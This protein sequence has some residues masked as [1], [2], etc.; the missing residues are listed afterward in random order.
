MD[1]FLQNLINGIALGSIYALIA[2]GYTMVYGVLRLINFAHGDVFMVGAF[3]GYYAA[4]T[5][6]SSARQPT[7]SRRARSCSCCCVRCVV[8]GALGPD[9]AARLPAAAHAPRLTS[10][11]TAIGV[12]LLLENGG[13]LRVR[14]R[15]EV[16]PAA[17]RKHQIALLGGDDHVDTS[18]IVLVV[19]L[20]L[21]AGLQY[22]VYRTQVRPRD[23]RGVVQ[24]DGRGADGDPDR[25][26]HLVHVRARLD[27]RGGAAASWSALD[28]R[29]STR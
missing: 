27:A 20:V 4:R 23:A 10:L 18:V 14:R 19:A 15:P 29:R 25:P 3:M 12:S 5:A 26:R 6:R 24:L 22:I 13:Q 9:R 8:C 28:T 16:L 17:P 21:M 1:S 7:S 2:L 11:I